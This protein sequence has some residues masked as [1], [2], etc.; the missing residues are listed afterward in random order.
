MSM[1]GGRRLSL[2]LFAHPELPSKRVDGG[3]GC[4]GTGARASGSES[5]WRDGGPARALA[6]IA[7]V[8]SVAACGGVDRE[9]ALADADRIAATLPVYPD[10]KVVARAVVK[11]DAP[12]VGLE[13]LPWDG[14]SGYDRE[15]EYRL[16]ARAD[17]RKVIAFIERAFAPEWEAMAI[18]SGTG[19]ACWSRGDASVTVMTAPYTHRTQFPSYKLVVGTSGLGLC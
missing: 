5:G 12:D 2:P 3:R 6:L 7:T 13:G 18:E 1:N 4:R 9:D 15:V 10:G 17:G 11:Y 8:A 14:A 16:P 19:L